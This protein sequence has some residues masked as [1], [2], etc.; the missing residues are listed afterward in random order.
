MNFIQNSSKNAFWLHSI[1]QNKGKATMLV[2]VELTLGDNSNYPGE[3]YAEEIF[4]KW[5]NDRQIRGAGGDDI[6]YGGQGDDSL[7]GEQGSDLLYG[8]QDDDDL[9]GGA[10]ADSLYGGSGAD[11]LRGGTGNDLLD[12]GTGADVLDGGAGNDTMTGGW[13]SDE[14]LFYSNAAFN[15]ADLGSDRITDFDISQGDLINAD[16]I[17]LDRTTFSSL[18]T[19]VSSLNW[20]SSVDD[21]GQVQGNSAVIVYVKQTGELFYNPNGTERGFSG[22]G[23]DEN[24]FETASSGGRFATLQNAPQNLDRFDFRFQL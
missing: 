12:G 21:R 11:V 7:F 24:L 20:F 22:R 6:I 14:F 10:E 13:G 1:R 4:A 15:R 8:E 16:L 23:L 18:P 19:S 2:K 5:G 3:N 17:V 9:Y